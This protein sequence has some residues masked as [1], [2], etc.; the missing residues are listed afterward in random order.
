MPYLIAYLIATA[1]PR[2]CQSERLLS[3]FWGARGRRLISITLLFYSDFK[4]GRYNFQDFY[5]KFRSHLRANPVFGGVYRIMWSPR[6]FA[7]WNLAPYEYTHAH[8]ESETKVNIEQNLSRWRLSRATD[9]AA[10]PVYE[11]ECTGAAAAAAAI[12]EIE[13]ET[14]H[15]IT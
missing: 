3:A 13:S 11:S 14:L 9:C 1:A 10:L 12:A 15:T 6:F 8:R 2:D 7:F 5:S 4:C